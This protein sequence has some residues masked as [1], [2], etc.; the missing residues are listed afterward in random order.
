MLKFISVLLHYP[1]DAVLD[2]H[3]VLR[4]MIIRQFFR[5]KG[6]KVYWVDKARLERRWLL[7][8]KNTHKRQLR[9]VT[10]CFTDEFR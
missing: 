4:T 5:L 1:F 9:P 2:L 7:N 3:D 8:S 6:R 10:V